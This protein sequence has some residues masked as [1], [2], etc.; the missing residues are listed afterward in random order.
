MAPMKAREFVERFGWA[1]ATRI[2]QA[3]GTTREY[4]YQVATGR[5][6][7]SPSL[8]MRLVHASGGRLDFMALVLSTP[9]RASSA[10]LDGSP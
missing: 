2:A 3:A 10:A 9:A 8:A 4:F 1:E 7:A 5:R 6:N